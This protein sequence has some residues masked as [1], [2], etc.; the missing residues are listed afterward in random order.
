MWLRVLGWP[1]YEK[2]DGSAGRVPLHHT[3]NKCWLYWACPTQHRF[4]MLVKMF[5]ILDIFC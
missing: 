3:S 1:H 4:V 2:D 5:N